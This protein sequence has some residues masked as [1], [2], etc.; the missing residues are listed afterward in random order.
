M[1]LATCQEKSTQ[2]S[3]FNFILRLMS[4]GLFQQ[5]ICDL[6]L[7]LVHRDLET[8]V[9]VKLSQ[10]TLPLNYLF[11]SFFVSVTGILIRQPELFSQGC[12]ILK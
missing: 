12:L 11:K 5:L 10:M 3:L 7:Q 2:L 4:S 8:L 1:I 6:N 9:R